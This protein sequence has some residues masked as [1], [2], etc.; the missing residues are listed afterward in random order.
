MTLATQ[1]LAAHVALLHSPAAGKDEL[2]SR[3]SNPSPGRK[4]FLRYIK[5]RAYDKYNPALHPKFFEL[6]AYCLVA[7]NDKRYLWQLLYTKHVPAALASTGR[8]DYTW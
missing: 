4:A 6:V 5:S 7:E 2:R 1:I 8:P 3:Y